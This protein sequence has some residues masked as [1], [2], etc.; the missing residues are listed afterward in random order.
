ML[1]PERGPRRRESGRRNPKA[2]LGASVS[3][4]APSRTEVRRGVALKNSNTSAREPQRGWQTGRH[5]NLP[6]QMSYGAKEC[7]EKIGTWFL[8]RFAAE[9]KKAG[10]PMRRLLGADPECNPYFLT[11]LLHRLCALAFESTEKAVQK[12]R[13]A[14]PKFKHL[15]AL[16]RQAEMDLGSLANLRVAASL[17]CRTA[18]IISA[19][20]RNYR[21]SPQEV[22]AFAS[23]CGRM[24]GFVEIIAEVIRAQIH[25]NSDQRH[26]YQVALEAHLRAGLKA[27]SVSQFAQELLDCADAT[28]AQPEERRDWDS[29]VRAVHRS[30]RQ[31][32]KY[33]KKVQE[34]AIRDRG[35]TSQDDIERWCR[36]NREDCQLIAS[37]LDAEM[38]RLDH[39]STRPKRRQKIH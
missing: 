10:N 3:S 36:L 19:R 21:P 13:T 12:A 9:L 5:D 27:S 35:I 32:P 11:F 1:P 18:E 30:K 17:G 23:E 6:N 16:L 37:A 7:P 15:P 22:V 38:T 2:H 29:I 34:R 28:F 20:S 26:V 33:Y 4:Y 39:P 31:T 25:G 8:K 14:L 24:A